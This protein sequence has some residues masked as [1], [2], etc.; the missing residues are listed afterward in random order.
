MNRKDDFLIIEITGPFS[1]GRTT[2]AKFFETELSTVK[3]K[4]VSLK[5]KIDADIPEWYN[6]KNKHNK[7]RKEIVKLLRRRQMSCSP[8][9]CEICQYLYIPTYSFLG[10]PLSISRL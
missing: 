2:A 4:Y 7:S 10:L 5:E 9:Y 6:N 1:S 3:K 8:R